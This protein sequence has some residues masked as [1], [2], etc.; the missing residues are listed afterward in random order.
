MVAGNALTNLN[1]T[2]SILSNGVLEV[3]FAGLQL[4]GKTQ[5]WSIVLDAHR[6][7]YEPRLIKR[8]IAGSAIMEFVFESHTNVTIWSDGQRTG[9]ITIPLA[10]SYSGAELKGGEP[11]PV[12][13]GRTELVSVRVPKELPASLFQVD[14]ANALY[15]WDRDLNKPVKT[16]GPYALVQKKTSWA[17][18]AVFGNNGAGL[19]R[20]VVVAIPEAGKGPE[21]VGPMLR[22]SRFD[23][24][25][26]RYGKQIPALDAGRYSAG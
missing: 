8:V 22:S 19:A 6:T 25:G 14:E 11:V 12:L 21:K 20:N 9:S 10:F 3:T 16:A 13:R 23:S 15:V 1:Y 18:F 26:R 7:E 4:E 5:Y 2:R 17:R 24:P